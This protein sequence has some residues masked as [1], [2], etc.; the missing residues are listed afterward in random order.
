M[1][2]FERRWCQTLMGAIIPPA[3]GAVPALADLDLTDFWRRFD[4]AAP[5]HLKLGLRV[6]TWLFGARLHALPPGDR[7]GAL[8]RFARTPLVG[9]LLEV[10]KIVACFAWFDRADVQTAYRAD[11]R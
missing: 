8:Q 5:F 9:D 2:G 11:A 1:T 4:A 7:E 10:A 6:A 3:D